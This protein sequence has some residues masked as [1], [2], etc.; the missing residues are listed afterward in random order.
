[1]SSSLRAV[2][3]GVLRQALYPALE[4]VWGTGFFLVG[5]YQQ[6]HWRMRHLEFTG[7]A[8][9]GIVAPHPDDETGGCGGVACLHR[10]AGDTVSVLIVT[11]GSASR[12]GNVPPA[13]MAGRR[14]AEAQ[15]AAATL[16]LAGLELAGLPEGH[17][18]LAE[19]TAALVH[20]LAAV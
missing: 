4:E 13:E 16:G 12:A 18:P 8:R 6:W 15:A 5:L 17:W 14:A 11:D 3:R 10:A 1:M 7:G 2:G 20:W 19:G 9:V